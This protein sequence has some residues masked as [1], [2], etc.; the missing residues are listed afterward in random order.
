MVSVQARLEQAQYAINRGLSSRRACTL[1]KV[2]RSGLYYQH[3][4]PEKDAPVIAA[5]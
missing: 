5:K 1:F 2:S 4:M 3:K